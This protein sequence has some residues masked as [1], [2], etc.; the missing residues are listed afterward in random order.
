MFVISLV[1]VFGVPAKITRAS[2]VQTGAI[3]AGVY[4]QIK[5]CLNA[6]IARR[7]TR[8]KFA[9][10]NWYLQRGSVPVN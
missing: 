9:L 2:I 7:G 8:P 6:R 1:G 4:P 10:E 3:S 5:K